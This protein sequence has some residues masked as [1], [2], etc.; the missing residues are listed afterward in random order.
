MPIDSIFPKPVLT[1]TADTSGVQINPA[2]DFLHGVECWR[3]PAHHQCAINLIEY[4]NG[5]ITKLRL[6]KG[7]AAAP[8]ADVTTL[9]RRLTQAL[10]E[11]DRA[12]QSAQLEHG[13]VEHADAALVQCKA[14]LVEALALAERMQGER[15]AARAVAR[16]LYAHNR[17]LA[18]DLLMVVP[19]VDAD[20]E[21]HT[22]GSC[23]APL[24]AVRPGKWQCPNAP[25]D[26]SR[27][28]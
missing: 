17:E 8:T 10:D 24:E 2:G 12:R 23:G 18:P 5:V 13:L 16:R 26:Y 21:Q 25:H 9:T 27:E 28:P 14:E 6:P 3:D 15:D 4:Q 7:A 1:T 11:R 22:C 19:P 20:A